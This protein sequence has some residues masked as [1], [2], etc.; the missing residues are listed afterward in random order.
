MWALLKRLLQQ[1]IAGRTTSREEPVREE[2]AVS[3]SAEER[4]ESGMVT[5]RRGARG[6]EAEA[7]QQKLKA[8]GYYDGLLE[9]DF[10]P[11]REAAVKAFQ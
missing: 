6:T 11:G 5:L 4:E 1:L 7:F 3:G 10:G 8:L 9:G 2:L